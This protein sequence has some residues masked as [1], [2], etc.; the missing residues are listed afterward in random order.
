MSIRII[1]MDIDGTLTNNKRQLTEENRRTL[2][3]AE[4]KGV[5]LVLASGRPLS[6]LT[7]LAR[8]LQMDRYHGLLIA[9]NGSRVVDCE[10]GEVLYNKTMTVEEGRA[11]LEHM[12]KFRVRTMI[13]KG[14]YMY[15]TDVYDCN[16]MVDG[17]PKNIIEYETRGNRFKLCE[18]DDLAAFAD[19]PLNKILNAA[20]PEYLQA[21]YREMEEPFRET[22]SCMFTAPFYFEYTAKGV[23]K[24]TA[25]AH[26]L[27]Q[28]G[29]EAGELMAFGDAQN[30]ASMLAYAGLGI[31]MDNA[32]PEL[33]AVADEITLSN[34]ENGV[35]A[36]VK[37][38][39]NL[40]GNLE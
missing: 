6:G 32:V 11:V 14:E 39:L 9:F 25:L 1:S 23:D 21:H 12:K 13:D 3:R 8:E 4:E 40:C 27:P 35:A 7:K 2:I 5:R 19:Y 37:K 34:E 38:Y 33:K 28:L 29:Y 16:I 36:A 26:V 22:L 10:T 24:G 31:D 18:V 17:Q 15:V 20:D 30:D